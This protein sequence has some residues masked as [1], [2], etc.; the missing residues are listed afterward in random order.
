MHGINDSLQFQAHNALDKSY[1]YECHLSNCTWCVPIEKYNPATAQASST[2]KVS[3]LASH[4]ES[5]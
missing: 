4:A 1:P 2:P 3:M 5:L